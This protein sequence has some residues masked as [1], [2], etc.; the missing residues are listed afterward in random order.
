VLGVL[1]DGEVHS[2]RGVA[3]QLGLDLGGA[4]RA[5]LRLKDAGFIEEVVPTRTGMPGRFYKLAEGAAAEEPA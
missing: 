5:I 3:H 4:Y 2:S 1:A